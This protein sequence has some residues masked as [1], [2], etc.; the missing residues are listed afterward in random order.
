MAG[1][2]LRAAHERLWNVASVEMLPVSNSNAQSAFAKATVD[3]LEIGNIGN[4]QHLHIG[5]T[6][7][8]KVHKEYKGVLPFVFLES[9]AK[10]ISC[11]SCA[12]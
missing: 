3:K 5:N 12:A 1:I 6:F 9:G 2:A 4:W 8:H 10:R 7:S 11:L